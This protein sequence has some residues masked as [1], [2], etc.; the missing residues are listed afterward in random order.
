M[1]M[2]LKYNAKTGNWVGKLNMKKLQQDAHNDYTQ[3]KWKKQANIH[4][5]GKGG[6]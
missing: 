6:L 4:K 2:V 5:Q 3:D 1:R